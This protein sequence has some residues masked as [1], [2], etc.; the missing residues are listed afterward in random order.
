MRVPI[1]LR[2]VWIAVRIGLALVMMSGGSYFLYQG[3]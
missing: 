3:F 1:A 2:I